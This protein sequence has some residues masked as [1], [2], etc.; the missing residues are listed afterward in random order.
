MTDWIEARGR[1]K[2]HCSPSCLHQGRGANDCCTQQ[3]AVALQWEGGP[4]HH[5][6]DSSCFSAHM[7]LLTHC[8]THR[9]G[10]YFENAGGQ[11]CHFSPSPVNEG[12]LVGHQ[13]RGCYP[14]ET[15]ALTSC[16][17]HQRLLYPNFLHIPIDFVRN[18]QHYVEQFYIISHLKHGLREPTTPNK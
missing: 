6:R 18:L 16:M 3:M 13:L 9:K 1:E 5:P 17:G 4:S 11:L 7:V 8:L 12:A 15:L 14:S 2:H 10:F